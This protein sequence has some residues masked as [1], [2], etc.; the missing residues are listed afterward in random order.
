MGYGV[1]F[2]LILLVVLFVCCC[3][4]LICLYSVLFGLVFVLFIVLVMLFYGFIRILVVGDLGL[5]IWLL[6]CYLVAITSWSLVMWCC[7]L[8]DLVCGGWFWLD[9]G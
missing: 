3:L 8:F 1:C 5:V 6:F 2:D 7:V 9:G 4:G